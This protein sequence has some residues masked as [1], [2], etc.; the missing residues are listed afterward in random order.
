M[1]FSTIYWVSYYSYCALSYPVSIVY[2]FTFL[3]PYDKCCRAVTILFRLSVAFHT[4]LCLLLFVF[5]FFLVCLYLHS[6]NLLVPLC[7]IIIA[8]LL[9][10]CFFVLLCAIVKDNT[11]QTLRST[12]L[13]AS[14]GKGALFGKMN[15]IRV[16]ASIEYD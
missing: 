11:Q 9:L 15:S 14:K 1:Y 6:E 5:D 13:M 3:S 12:P 2:L 10:V 4:A 7:T 16:S 8:L